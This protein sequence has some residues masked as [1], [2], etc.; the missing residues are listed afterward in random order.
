M[1]IEEANRIAGIVGTADGGCV[2]CVGALVRSLNEDFP[3][4]IWEMKDWGEA[5]ERIEVTTVEHRMN[6]D[7]NLLE[8]PRKLT[9]ARKPNQTRSVTVEGRGG[10]RAT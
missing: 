2:H 10:V 4:F 3:E 8:T 1:N 6:T 7:V 9:V 5:N